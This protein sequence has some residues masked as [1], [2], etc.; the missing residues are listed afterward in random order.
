MVTIFS[1]EILHVLF[2]FYPYDSI[3]IFILPGTRGEPLIFSTSLK[4]FQTL[5]RNYWTFFFF[6]FWSPIKISQRFRTIFRVCSFNSSTPT[7]L[8][9]FVLTF[10]FL[11]K[12]KEMMLVILEAFRPMSTIRIEISPRT[13]LRRTIQNLYWS[14]FEP[15]GILS[16][17]PSEFLVKELFYV[18]FF[19][20]Q[21]EE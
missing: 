4:D 16:E 11:L 7:R 21:N 12:K 5:F 18:L 1:V 17:A 13:Y 6:S 20:L 15:P 10:F 3:N 8:N 2:W 19:K 9:Y 14:S